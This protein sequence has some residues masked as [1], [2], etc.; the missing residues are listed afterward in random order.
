M[1]RLFAWEQII[2]D[3]VD[4]MEIWQNEKAPREP[5]IAI[6]DRLLRAGR[7]VTAVGVSDWHR[8]PAPIDAAAVRV[9]ATA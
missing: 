3:A 1:R 7:R 2:P 9:L 4:A 6:W 8:P 5:E